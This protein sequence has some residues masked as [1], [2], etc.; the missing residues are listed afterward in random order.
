MIHSWWTRWT[1]NIRAT[2]QTQCH[3]NEA[4]RVREAVERTW[5]APCES[6]WWAIVNI[7][8]KTLTIS[9]RLRSSC[10]HITYW[11]NRR[12]MPSKWKVIHEEAER[13]WQRPS[14]VHYTVQIGKTYHSRHAFAHL[15]YRTDNFRKPSRDTVPYSFERRRKGYGQWHA[16]GESQS[17]ELNITDQQSLP[18]KETLV[19]P[20]KWM[21]WDFIVGSHVSRWWA[22]DGEPVFPNSGWHWEEGCRCRVNENEGKRADE[23][24]EMESRARTHNDMMRIRLLT[25]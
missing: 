22:T 21:F 4:P 10:I 17:E 19:P 8:Y 25:T 24:M 15:I 7:T 14:L 3:K 2:H 20:V 9:R 23:A 5:R 6:T 18:F 12:S 1:K 16:A 11:S 13:T